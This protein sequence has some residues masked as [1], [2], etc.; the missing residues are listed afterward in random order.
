MLHCTVL[1]CTPTGPCPGSFLQWPAS[2][3]PASGSSSISSSNCNLQ[4][5][6]LP[7]GT[8]T[9]TTI[10]WLPSLGTLHLRLRPHITPKSSPPT[11]HLPSHYPSL[12][13]LQQ[14]Q[15]IPYFTHPSSFFCHLL[16]QTSLPPPRLVHHLQRHPRYCCMPTRLLCSAPSCCRRRRRRTSLS[17][18]PPCRP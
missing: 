15:P 14:Y 18:V 13:L 11:H 9:D 10:Q 2:S 8:T 1:H 17:F 3:F 6:L 12:P 7:I 4:L 5:R 16:H